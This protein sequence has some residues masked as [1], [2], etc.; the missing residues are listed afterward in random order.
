MVGHDDVGRAQTFHLM[1]QHVG[2]LVVD[3]VGDQKST[4]ATIIGKLLSIDCIGSD[5][6]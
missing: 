4:R 5:L 3:I 6:F 2:P 1:D